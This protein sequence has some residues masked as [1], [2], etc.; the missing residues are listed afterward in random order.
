MGIAEEALLIGGL[1][2]SVKSTEQMDRL[3]AV[4]CLGLIQAIRADAVTVD[5]AERQLFLPRVHDT[6]EKSG[7][8]QQV[9][10]L[11]LKGHVLDDVRR[12]VPYAFAETLAVME[13]DALAI[14]RNTPDLP[15]GEAG[16]WLE[17]YR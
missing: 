4:L 6:L 2:I 15:V 17:P 11:V 12:L 1:R 7:C 3:V 14:L 16:H 8:G 9:L 13:A 10:D 5:A